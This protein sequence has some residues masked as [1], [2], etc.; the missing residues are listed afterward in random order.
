LK[1]WYGHEPAGFQRFAE[2]LHAGSID[3]PGAQESLAKLI[4][5][6]EQP[7]IA[8]ASTLELMA[9]DPGSV[10]AT[11][12]RD[13]VRD[14]SP[15]V[16]RAAARALSG[17]APQA[18]ADTLAPLLNDRV[19]AVRIEAAEVLAGV[20]VDAL[21]DG[22]PAAL[23][24]AIDEY[25]AAQE[26]SADRPEAH[27]NLASLFARENRFAEAK[28]ELTTALSLDPSFTPAAVNLADLDRE[29][30]R[31]AA[32]ERV[33]R[34]AIS[35]SPDDASLQ[36]ALGLLLIRQGH[37]LEALDHLAAAAR[38]DLANARFVYVYAVA[39]NDAGQTGKALDV[40]EHNVAR[41]PYDRD[42]LAALA[43]FYQSAGNRRRAVIYAKRLA[44][45]EPNDAQVEQQLMQLKTET[46]P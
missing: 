46:Q 23:E 44:E 3:A 20:P 4:A 19:R 35:R 29:W 31:E 32:G 16:R 40:L 21:P 42:S 18:S 15:L 34:D 10:T 39:L 41:H 8:R 28:T 26:L 36:H 45:L 2:V 11:S 6:P 12:A 17:A 9:N 30:G 7:A 13:G 38:L 25:V 5:D 27:S 37:G 24:K 22:G 33:L 43:N 1:Q 14:T